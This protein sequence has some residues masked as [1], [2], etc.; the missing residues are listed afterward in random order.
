MP[1]RPDRNLAIERLLREGHAALAGADAGACVTAEEVAAWVDGG[2]SAGDAARVEAHLASC[3]ACQALLG[4]FARTEPAAAASR[5]RGVTRVLLPLAAAAVL[6]VGVWLVG[7]RQQPAS[8]PAPAERE[9]ARV[10]QL[11]APPATPVQPATPAQPPDES[12]L[13]R[14]V[15]GQ[16]SATLDRSDASREQ[17]AAARPVPMNEPAQDAA[18]AEQKAFAAAPQV[19]GVPAPAAG[20]NTTAQADATPRPQAA[21][22]AP[23]RSRLESVSAGAQLAQARA[24]DARLPLASPDGASRWRIVGT[25][26]EVSADG[27]VTWLPA[28]GV[29]PAE[30]ADVTSGTSPARGVSW[31]VGRGGLVL[32]TTDGRRFTRTAPPTPALLTAVEAMDGA[33]AVVRASDGRA[34]RT[35]NAGRTWVAV[36]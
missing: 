32:V 15:A 7:T 35:V 33:I 17:T 10:D 4:A 27:G 13:R 16:S 36:E 28:A 21:T 11:P 3:Q 26:L 12:S 24:V 5:S 2:L 25:A 23:E 29:T 1:T 9:L 19:T 31:L 34:W 14:R 20:A 8:V 6:V 22:S 18:P 30:L